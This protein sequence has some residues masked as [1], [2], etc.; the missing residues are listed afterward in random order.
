M[1]QKQEMIF[2]EGEYLQ[3][4]KELIEEKR[5]YISAHPERSKSDFSEL[6]G[7]IGALKDTHN[8]PH[9]RRKTLLETRDVI[10]CVNENEG[11]LR[12]GTNTYLVPGSLSSIHRLMKNEVLTARDISLITGDG[13]SMQE[14][15]RFVKLEKNGHGLAQKHFIQ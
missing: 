5:E 15:I 9:E 14:G 10:Q 8:F 6:I 12:F 4:L 7:A 13:V 1:K 3:D 11:E 2:Q